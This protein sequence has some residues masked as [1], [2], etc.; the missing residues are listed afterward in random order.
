M[1]LG[2]LALFRARQ[3]I[4]H[5]ALSEA[6]SCNVRALPFRVHN[7][8]PLLVLV[9][10]VLDC[11]LLALLPL[12]LYVMFCYSCCCCTVQVEDFLHHAGIEGVYE[13]GT[14]LVYRAMLHLGSVA[15]VAQGRVSAL[16]GVRSGTGQSPGFELEDLELVTA[17]SRDVVLSTSH[18]IMTAQRESS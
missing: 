15:R 12:L 18:D 17:V 8:C 1:Y 6:C 10:A 11:A 4:Y 3:L 14:P 13:L 2:P 7:G 16:K 9:F 5:G